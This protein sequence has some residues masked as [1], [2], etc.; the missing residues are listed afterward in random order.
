MK[1]KL[2]ALVVLVCAVVGIYGV[3]VHP[4]FSWSANRDTLADPV[5]PRTSGGGAND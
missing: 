5:K 4:P 2:A 3:S 1:F